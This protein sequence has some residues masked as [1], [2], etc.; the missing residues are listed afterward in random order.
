MKGAVGVSLKITILD[1]NPGSGGIRR[2][3]SRMYTVPYLFI[4]KMGL[5]IP[6]SQ[7]VSEESIR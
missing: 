5:V 4:C 6:T 1:S 3:V 7:S 2:S